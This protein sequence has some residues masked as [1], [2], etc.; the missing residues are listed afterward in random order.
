[1]QKIRLIGTKIKTGIPPLDTPI[2]FLAAEFGCDPAWY[3]GWCFQS[4]LPGQEVSYYVFPF[5]YGYPATNPP[6]HA[7]PYLNQYAIIKDSNILKVIHESYSFLKVES[8]SSIF[9]QLPMELFI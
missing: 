8:V 3:P 4:S 5:H 7:P 6:F 2:I 1:M 9:K